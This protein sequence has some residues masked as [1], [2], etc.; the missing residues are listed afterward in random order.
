MKNN[1]VRL[2]ES[3]TASY[4]R[5]HSVELPPDFPLREFAA[6]TWRG[7]GYIRHLS[8]ATKSDVENFLR[9]KAPRHF[10]YSS[11]R[12]DQPGLDDMDAKGWR[13]ADIVFDIDA[14]HLPGCDKSIVKVTN[15]F[16]EEVSFI[17]E[18]CI[19]EA[20]RHTEVLY[21]IIV[22]ELGFGRES[23]RI[24]FSG[25][26]GFHLTVYLKD[27]ERI[28]KAGSEFRRELANY[29][30]GAGLA[31]ETLHPWRKLGSRKRGLAPIP[32][33]ASMAGFRGRVARVAA[34]IIDSSLRRVFYADP[35]EAARLYALHRGDIDSVIE[36]A[37]VYAS[38]GIDTQVTVDTKRL[39][40]APNSI[41]GKTMLLVKPLT[42]SSLQGFLMEETLSPFRGHGSIRVRVVV[43][44]PSTI[45]I[46]GH[47]LRLRKGDSPRLPYPVGLFLMAKGVAVAAEKS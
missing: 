34:K 41:N 45:E 3:L 28:A 32:P 29:I 37:L 40:R 10:Y 43:E 21:E 15:I 19:S 44:V 20:A 5:K 46:L 2:L 33:L 38:P 18:R 6:Q 12:Y 25:H 17:E 26:R 13:S 42:P 35:I 11:A 47:R 14:D 31:E 36:K 4:Y 22:E 39:I 27:T 23:V 16:G 30:R 24:E 8:F 9:Q 7:R 1:L